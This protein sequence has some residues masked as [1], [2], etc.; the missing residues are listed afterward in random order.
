MRS[1][2]FIFWIVIVGFLNISVLGQEI[3]F[4]DSITWRPLLKISDT[5]SGETKY[6]FNFSNIAYHGNYSVLP[7]YEG[8]VKLNASESGHVLLTQTYY[9]ELPVEEMIA[10]S[11]TAHLTDSIVID[12]SI[13]KERKVSYLIYSFAP[14]RKNAN[15]GKIERLKYFSLKVLPDKGETL[16]KSARAQKRFAEQSI[17]SSGNWYKFE[18]NKS[19]V[20]QI[21]FADLKNLGIQNPEQ[22]RIFGNGGKMLSEIYTGNVP[23]EP[24]EIPVMM[25]TNYILF[26]AEGPVTW[27]YDTVKNSYSHH[28][29]RFSDYTYYYI[30]ESAGGKRITQTTPPINTPTVQVNSFDALDYHE[31]NTNNLLGSGR[32]WYGEDYKFSGSVLIPFNFPGIIGTEPVKFEAQVVGRSNSVNSFSFQQNNK[33]IGSVSVQPVDL[34]TLTDFA[35]VVSYNNTFNS[36]L[37]DITINVA[38]DNNGNS[39][40]EGWLG[41]LSLAARENLAMYTSQLAFRDSRSISKGNTGSFSISNAAANVQVWDIT[42]LHE[43]NQ[44]SGTTQGSIFSFNATLDQLH[45]YIAFDPQKNL[46]RPIF[47]TENNGKIDVQNLHGLHNI[48]MV[49]ISHQKFLNQAQE[50]ADLHS[51]KDGLT[52]VVV[53]PDQIDNEFSSGMPD[54]AA[55]R[56]F[57]KM[58]YDKS[59]SAADMPKY[60]LLF[61]DGSYDNKTPVSSHNS[62]YIMT[63][64]SENS[65]SPSYSYVSDDYFGLLDDNENISTGLLDIG[66]GRLPVTDTA[67]QAQNVVDKIKSYIAHKTLGD[68]RNRLCIVADDEEAN[69][70]MSQADQL[71]TYVTNNYPSLNIKKIYLDAYPQISTSTGQRYPDVTLDLLN[72]LNRGTLIVN[73]IG[74]GGE[75]GLAAEQ[76]VTVT[77]INQWK[78]DLYPLFVTATCEFGRYDDFKKRS[79]G[80]MVLLN[81]DGGGIGLITTTR[82]VYADLNYELNL[83]FYQ[84]AFA[85]TSDNSAFRLGDIVRKTKNGSSNDVNKLCFTL[86]GDPALSLAYPKYC[87]IVTDSINHKPIDPV[88]T[89]N[90]YSSITICGHIADENGAGVVDFNGILYPTVFD[91]AKKI[92]TLANDN[93]TPFDFYAQNNI[94]FKGKETIKNGKFTFNFIMPRDIDYNFGSGKIDYYAH[95]SVNDVSGFF[96]KVVIGS[97]SAN[98]DTSA[99]NSKP[100]IKLYMND[101]TFVN[102]GITDEYPTLLALVS[103]QHGINP[104][105]N[106]L[107]HDILATLDNDSKQIYILN[108]YFQTDLDNYKQG[109]VAFKFP[110]LTAGEH[111]VTFKIWNIFNNSEQA[112]LKFIVRGADNLSIQKVYNYPNP[113]SDYTNF[114]FEHNQNDM[115]LDITI[116]IFNMAGGKV[117]ELKATLLSTGYTSTPIFWDGKDENGNKIRQG[118]YI[119]RIL[120]R[121]LKGSVLSKAQKMIIMN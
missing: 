43:V 94:L 96:N 79:A 19:G 95:D 70:F 114:F 6:L 54:P 21:T 12:Y 66:I 55:I 74:H 34:G 18:V 64:E 89:L 116:D 112:T 31:E 61:G 17:F 46:L 28:K 42:D 10:I 107:G 68:W 113:F 53:T 71:A 83:Q 40:A 120:L 73:Y 67:N 109:S 29:H 20:Y 85:K 84:N 22:V 63:Y 26:Y 99:D 76:I 25:M 65:L 4:S 9:Q 90:A 5:V 13:A 11:P 80:E 47:L 38:F 2:R 30:T 14:F 105:G 77:D 15:S 60:L 35:N 7:T 59:T 33:S 72:Q 93:G 45:E 36:G 24:E 101:T 52:T 1:I 115:N 39:L 62:N 87:G 98:L 49:I 106:S 57:M 3:N 8:K 86:L 56:N 88:D 51:Q 82:V 81:P 117:K 97:I 104:G 37:E 103:D 91:K 16:L 69:M 48:D 119:Y 27:S 100:F 92:T 23:D 102:G 32:E 75:T 78:N 41:Y 121:S 58:L 50:L 108:S 110:R 44:L 118:I 111:T